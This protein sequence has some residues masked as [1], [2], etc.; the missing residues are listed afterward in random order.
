MSFVRFVTRYVRWYH[1]IS[2]LLG[3]AAITGMVWWFIERSR[4]SS[5]RWGDETDLVE[6]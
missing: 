4:G 1:M 3:I 2:L 5:F 6:E